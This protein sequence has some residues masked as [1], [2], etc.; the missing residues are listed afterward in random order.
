MHGRNAFFFFLGGYDFL[1]G[2]TCNMTS[3]MPFHA[4][5]AREHAEEHV[6]FEEKMSGM[7]LSHPATAVAP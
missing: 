4:C 3:F 1:R 6:L 2:A 7:Q 5:M